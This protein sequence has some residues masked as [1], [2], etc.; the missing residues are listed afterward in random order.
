MN[1]KQLEFARN[2]LLT[3]DGTDSAIKAGYSEHS[4][5]VTASKLLNHAGVKAY[6]ATQQT[7]NAKKFEV[8]AEDKMKVLWSIASEKAEAKDADRIN[9]INVL[10]RMQGHEQVKDQDN[11]G[12]TT[13]VIAVLPDNGREI[14]VV[15]Q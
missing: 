13:L 7:K 10:N 14:K 1:S 2:Y 11:G 9:A 4:A 5:S 15:N 6:L 3:G 12:T 8:L